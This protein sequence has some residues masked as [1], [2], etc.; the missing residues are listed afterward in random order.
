M[1]GRHVPDSRS[2][3]FDGASPGLRGSLVIIPRNIQY[4]HP[5]LAQDSDHVVDL[6]LQP[7]EILEVDGLFALP[8]GLELHP[9][10]DPLVADLRAG[11]DPQADGRHL[12]E[13]SHD[14]VEVCVGSELPLFHEPHLQLEVCEGCVS[15]EAAV[16]DCVTQALHHEALGVEMHPEPGRELMGLQGVR[17]SSGI[18]VVVCQVRVP[19][20]LV[21]PSLLVRLEEGQSGGAE[22]LPKFAC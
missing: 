1:G 20:S 3:G 11:Q 9:S 17:P 13:S 19:P 18:L 7:L 12:H 5:P 16:Q 14:V 10:S 22:R 4:G 8:A 21:S 15:I 2:Q 6:P